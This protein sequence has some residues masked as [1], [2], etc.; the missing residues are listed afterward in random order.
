VAWRVWQY[1]VQR[2][3]DRAFAPLDKNRDRKCRRR[4]SK[5]QGYCVAA[6][7]AQIV[8][9]GLARGSVAFASR[10]VIAAVRTN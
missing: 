9:I 4:A 8:V 7:A 1:A 10:A 5:I 3:E 2:H 6:L